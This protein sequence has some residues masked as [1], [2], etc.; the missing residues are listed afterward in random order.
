MS[1]VIP[2][3][4]AP[5][6]DVD[7]SPT[8][9]VLPEALSQQEWVG[10]GRKLRTMEQS[11][12]WWIG[13]WLAYGERKYGDI[14]AAAETTGYSRGALYNAKYVATTFEPSSRDETLPWSL[15]KSAAGLPPE[16]R[17][18][19][20]S[21]A[22]ERG[23]SQRDLVAEIK[24]RKGATLPRREV[25]PDS[26]FGYAL[27]SLSRF[28]GAIFDLDPA[29]FTGEDKGAPAI[30]EARQVLCYLLITEAGFREIDVAE[31]LGRHHST[32]SHA[33]D[34]ITELREDPAIDRT[35]SWLGDT[36]RSLVEA[37]EAFK[38]LGVRAA[39]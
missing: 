27:R 4:E 11:V 30:V 15:H 28:L 33:M 5:L 26:S 16:Q 17:H 38:R 23:W 12:M 19:V 3:N 14:S 32:I 35:F 1:E 13:D 31:G 21:V 22:A 20:L 39:A 36:Y 37:Q 18:E 7:W 24:R 2:L 10:I 25:A 29:E 9:L 6:P 34:V 8:A